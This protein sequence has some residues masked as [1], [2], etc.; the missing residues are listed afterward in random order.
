LAH[1]DGSLKT[2]RVVGLTWCGRIIVV[3][4][5]LTLG[6]ALLP[7]ALQYVKKT[8][9][10]LFVSEEIVIIFTKNTSV[11]AAFCSIAQC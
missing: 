6:I 1:H 10:P 2:V 8:A 7:K 4:K 9:V 3:Y 11:A 5:K